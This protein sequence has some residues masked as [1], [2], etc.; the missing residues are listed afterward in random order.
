MCQSR[1]CAVTEEFALHVPKLRV[2]T[3]AGFARPYTTL[4]TKRQ[5]QQ[6][7][8]DGP[9][10][11]DDTAL[12]VSAYPREESAEMFGDDTTPEEPRKSALRATEKLPRSPQEEKRK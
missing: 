3:V 2:F 10:E 5:I 11:V 4:D 1:P 8:A 6:W 12:D 9:E 7:E